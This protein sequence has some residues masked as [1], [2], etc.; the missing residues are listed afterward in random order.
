MLDDLSLKGLCGQLLKSSVNICGQIPSS[1]NSDI[2]RLVCLDAVGRVGGLMCDDKRKVN[3]LEQLS[4]LCPQAGD[5]LGVGRGEEQARRGE[6]E[7]E[8]K[9]FFHVFVG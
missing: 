4:L 7:D 3:F 6:S 9:S 5:L 2:L 8:D 1:I